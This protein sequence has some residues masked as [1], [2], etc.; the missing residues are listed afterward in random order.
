MSTTTFEKGLAEVRD[1]LERIEGELHDLDTSLER[2]QADAAETAW[3][4]REA[5]EAA[6][7]AA[8]SRRIALGDLTTRLRDAANGASNPSIPTNRKEEK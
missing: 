4:A 7:G 6:I 8:R 3:K 1:R 5:A 2:L